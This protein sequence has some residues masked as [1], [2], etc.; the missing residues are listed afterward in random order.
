MGALL[1]DACLVGG[2]GRRVVR[3]APESLSIWA[4][5]GLRA[6]SLRGPGTGGPCLR[7]A[8][9]LRLHLFALPATLAAYLVP[10]AGLSPYLPAHPL[11]QCGIRA[12][13]GPG[14][15]RQGVPAPSGSLSVTP[16]R[17]FGK[18]LWTLSFLGL[19]PWEESAPSPSQPSF[20]VLVGRARAA[21]GEGKGLAAQSAHP[22]PA[23]RTPKPR[24]GGRTQPGQGQ[25]GGGLARR[26]GRG[27]S[28][29][30][31]GARGR[32]PGRPGTF[33]RQGAGGGTA[34]FSPAER[35]TRGS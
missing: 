14:K 30:G 20:W 5:V 11:A 25:T 28:R 21:T 7:P 15:P 29:L 6:G 13:A 34:A 2:G 22:Q 9:W 19:L 27:R 16:G 31:G 3:V 17:V 23:P 12:L 32:V 33:P 18:G 8:C 1:A 35:P 24:P 26:V 10:P 4:P